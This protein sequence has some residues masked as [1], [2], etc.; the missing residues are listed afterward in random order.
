MEALAHE[1]ELLTKGIGAH[2]ADI[3][4][5][6][7]VFWFGTIYDADTFVSSFPSPENEPVTVDAWVKSTIIPNPALNEAD[8]STSWRLHE[9]TC[10]I[11]SAINYE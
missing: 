3:A 7:V 6:A 9:L 1:L 2:E 11:W 10:N 4:Q 8:I 5:L